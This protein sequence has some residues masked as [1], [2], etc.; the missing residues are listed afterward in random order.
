M[1]ILIASAPASISACAPS[2]VATLPAMTATLLVARWMRRTCSSTCSE[3]PCAV[4]TTRQ[5]TPAAIK[6]S[7][8]AKPLSPTVVAAA[9]RRRPSASLAAFGWAVAFSMSLTVI[10][11]TQ[12]PASSTT[13]SFSIRCWCR[14][15]RASS[16]LTPSPTVITLRVMSSATGSRGSS[17]KRTSRLVRM[18]TSLPGLPSGPGSTTGM[19]EIEARFITASASASVAS[20][21]MVIG[22]TTMPLSKRL[23]LRTSSAWS[24]GSRLRW[25]TPMPPACAMAMASR[26][27]VT[28]SIAEETIGR[29]RR[30][31]AGE[32]GRDAD[33]ARHDRRVA[34]PQEDVVERQPLGK[35]AVPIRHRDSSFVRLRRAGRLMARL[36]TT[37]EQ[38]FLAR[39]GRRRRLPHHRPAD[40]PP[41]VIQDHRLAQYTS[42]TRQA[43]RGHATC[44]LNASA[45]PFMQ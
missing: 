21:K 4:S 5:S 34:G 13:T 45:R 38:K 23:T 44:G 15:R 27:S 41:D 40:G 16:R 24:A 32:T 14:S 12:R 35:A 9:T 31:R 28:V 10:R 19:P 6:S 11:P 22:S 29:L 30:D 7:A 37:P 42:S 1:P 17:A 43:N 20:G 3:W 2:R 33:G 18:P 8:R 36:P 39:W 26:A 25:M